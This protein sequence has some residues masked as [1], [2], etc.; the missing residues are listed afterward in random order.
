VAGA[1]VKMSLRDGYVVIA[2]RGE[3]DLC[4]AASVMPA[5]MAPA[6]SGARIIVDLAD[7]AFV[8]CSS[9]R[10]LASAREQARRAGGDL[11]LVGPQPI[12]LR[13]L[14]LTDVINHWPEFTS[15]DDAVS[16]AGGARPA[17]LAPQLA[18]A[19]D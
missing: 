18:A 7:L 6:E 4:T 13:L 15:V 11:L 14:L 1:H 9:L 16:G 12:V 8:D 5:F 10:E 19:V 2:L 17:C 3:L